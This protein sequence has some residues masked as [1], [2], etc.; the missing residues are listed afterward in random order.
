MNITYDEI[1]EG[2]LKAIDEGETSESLYIR[3]IK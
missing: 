3:R 1:I 2:A